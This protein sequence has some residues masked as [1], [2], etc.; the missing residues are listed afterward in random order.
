MKVCKIEKERTVVDTTHKICGNYCCAKMKEL[1]RIKDFNAEGICYNTRDNKF[2]ASLELYQGEY[3]D[4]VRS[5]EIHY[6]PFCGENLNEESP[7][8]QQIDAETKQ[9]RNDMI[10]LFLLIFGI[11]ALF[12]AALFVG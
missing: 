10:L 5:V 2:V 11:L 1:L 8:K 4:Y 7:A 3:D 12:I 9:K 6:C